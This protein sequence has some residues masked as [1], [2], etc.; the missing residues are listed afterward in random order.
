[1][2]YGHILM[3]GISGSGRKSYCKLAAFIADCHLNTTFIHKSYTFA[4]WRKDLKSI[5][6]SSGFNV[7][8][9]TVYLFSD[10]QV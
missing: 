9:H 5:L 8:Q 7:N 10:Y 1:M 6:M 4:D 3:I 2:P